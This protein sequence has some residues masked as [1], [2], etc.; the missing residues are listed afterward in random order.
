LANP[1]LQGSFPFAIT[2][3]VCS[4]ILFLPI[5]EK[6]GGNLVAPA[7]LRWGAGSAQKF[8]NDLVLEFGTE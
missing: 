2:A 8:F 1:L 7:D 3:Q 4:T 6:A 5:V